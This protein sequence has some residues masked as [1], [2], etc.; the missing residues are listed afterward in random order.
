MIKRLKH[1]EIRKPAEGVQFVNESEG[2]SVCCQGWG[3]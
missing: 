3:S 2:K 1:R